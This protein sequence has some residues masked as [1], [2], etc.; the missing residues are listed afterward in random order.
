VLEGHIRRTRLG[1]SKHPEVF[2]ALSD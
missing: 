2:R 1:L